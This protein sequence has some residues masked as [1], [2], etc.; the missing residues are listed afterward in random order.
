MNGYNFTERVRKVLAMGRDEAARLQHEYVGTEHI[1][2]GLIAEGEGVAATVLQ[3]LG[4]DLDELKLGIE[5]IVKKGKPGTLPGSDLPYTSRGKKVLELAMTE[6]RELN[7]R[8]VGTEHVLLGLVREHSGIG[9]QVLLDRGV[10]SDSARAEVLRILGTEESKSGKHDP[11]AAPA[12]A[13]DSMFAVVPPHTA[14]RVRDVMRHAEDIAT[15]LRAA[16]LLPVHVAIAMLRNG[17]G[18]ANAILDRSNVD[19]PELIRALM[20]EASTIAPADELQP[21][22]TFGQ[23]MITFAR[24]VE[25]ETRWRHAP[26]TTLNILLALLD[27]VKEVAAIF[28]AQGIDAARVR[29]EAR[30][31][32]G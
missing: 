16:E 6:A 1:L 24:Q 2:L 20:S 23:F 9:A 5:R 22:L 18:L 31:M 19:R 12:P 11:S 21:R 14:E 29:S 32:S 4:V 17:E 8:Y 26:P 7:H 13:K 27:N 15:E 28:E 25:S 10:T 3:N 30:R